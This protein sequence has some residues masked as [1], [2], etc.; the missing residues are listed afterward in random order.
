MGDIVVVI[1]DGMNDV[2]V[3]KIVDVGFLMGI[4]GIEVVKE[5]FVIIFMDDN[6]ISIVKVFKWGC[7]VNDVV[8]CFF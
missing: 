8:K 1:G 5:V 3:L 4:V 7:V 2:F 6:F